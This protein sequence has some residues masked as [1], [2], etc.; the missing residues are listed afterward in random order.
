M[1]A[2][3]H[4]AVRSHQEIAALRRSG[5]VA[6]QILREIIA[7]VRPGVTTR[8][9]D[10]VARTRI[11]AA[12]AQPAF[13]GY[14]GFPA[15]LCTSVNDI[16]VHGVP[17][18]RPLQ[19]GDTLGLDFGVVLNGWYSDFAVTVPVGVVSVDALR[20]IAATRE[21]LDIGI[22][23]ARVGQRIGDISAAIQQHVEG[24]G[25][26]VIRELAGHGVGT[27]LHG[28]PEV[29]NYGKAGTGLKFEEGMVFAIEPITAFSTQHVKRSKDGFGYVTDNGCLAAHFEHTIAV[30]KNGPE[31]LTLP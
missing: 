31:I 7:L 28:P 4:I 25:F 24:A 8:E 16:A 23:H 3:S 11:A 13:Q 2:S 5:A 27:S 15:A 10:A 30:T 21:A 9:L 22:A 6:A 29:P 19:S 17:S 20:L 1:I 12:G 18:D 14:G 26:E